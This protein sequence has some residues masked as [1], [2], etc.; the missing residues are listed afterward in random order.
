M[1]QPM[2]RTEAPTVRRFLLG[3]G[4]SKPAGLP[5]GTEILKPVLDVARRFFRSYSHR[6]HLE[7]AVTR[8]EAFLAATAPAAAA[9]DV[10]QFGAWLDMEH[11]LDLRGS[12]TFSKHGNEAGLQLRWAIGKVLH[13]ATPVKIPQL[14]LDFCSQLNTTDEILTLN[15]DMLLER[16]LEAVELPFRRFPNRYSE[17]SDWSSTVDTSGPDELCIM[18]LHGSIDWTYLPTLREPDGEHLRPLVDGPR[19][20]DDPLTR[21]AS[22]QLSSSTS[23]TTLV[24]TGRYCPPS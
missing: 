12:D 23:T 1:L 9:F 14:Y 19:Q 5:L 18:K 6:S 24:R 2:D 13:D 7:E 20:P 16:A 10:E 4:F 21:S 17:V 3:A 15:Y 11:T 8:Y 22:F